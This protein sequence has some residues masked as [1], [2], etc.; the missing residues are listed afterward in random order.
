MK[1]S[2]AASISGLIEVIAVYDPKTI[3]DIGA[4]SGKYGMLCREYVKGLE[5]M[6][7]VEPDDMWN[8]TI[9]YDQIF[10]GKIEDFEFYR[11]YDLAIMF[12]VIGYFDKE[13]GLGVIKKIL[14]HCN[15]LM[16]TFEKDAHGHTTQWCNDDFKGAILTDLPEEVLVYY[17]L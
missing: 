8:G 17:G 10:H 14:K 16:L 7:A 1:T 12:S 15:S 3:V 11:D 2:N 9:W 5:T 4:G 6:D 13:V